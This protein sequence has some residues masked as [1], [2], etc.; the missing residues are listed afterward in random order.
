MAAFKERVH[1]WVWIILFFIIA[2]WFYPPAGLLTIICMLAPVV[3]AFLKGRVWCGFFCPRGSFNDLVLAKWSR[4]R[5]LPGFLTATWFR[6]T[7]LILLLGAFTIQII[8]AQRNPVAVGTAFWRMIC[9]TTGLTI[10]LGT[11]YHQRSWCRICPMGT[12]AGYA[13]G[14]R[15]VGNRIQ[16]V[17]FKKDRCLDCKLCNK[18]CPLAIPVHTFKAAGRVNDPDC[19]KC[20]ACIHS[21]PQ[22]ALYLA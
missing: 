15:P 18:I 10:L 20:Q 17:S 13:A 7:F 21:C 1:Q 4:R 22:K 12:L 3:V 9:S 6:L 16:Q 2:G 5:P 11:V 8:L 14:L 19:L